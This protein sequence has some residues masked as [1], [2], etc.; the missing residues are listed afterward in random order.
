MTLQITIVDMAGKKFRAEVPEDIAVG[1]ILPQIVNKLRLPNTGYADRP[2]RYRLVHNGLHI[3]E[4]D[5]LEGVGV[6][7]GDTIRLVVDLVAGAPIPDFL[8]IAASV[9]TVVQVIL[10]VVDMWSKK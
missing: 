4:D 6:Q 3:R 7:H 8:I 9:A 1:R 5:T 10:M 2:L